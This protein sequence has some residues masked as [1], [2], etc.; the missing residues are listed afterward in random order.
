MASVFWWRLTSC[1]ALFWY[2]SLRNSCRYSD[3]CVWRGTFKD[4]VRLL[5]AMKQYLKRIKRH[6]PWLDL[7]RFKLTQALHLTTESW[8]EHKRCANALMLV[9]GRSAKSSPFH[10]LSNCGA[11]WRF[12]R[13]CCVFFSLFLS[14]KRHQNGTHTPG[15]WGRMCSY[16]LRFQREPCQS[17]THFKQHWILQPDLFSPLYTFLKTCSNGNYT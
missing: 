3:P 12:F 4:E 17:V 5:T 7:R 13:N 15:L 1:L 10:L 2:L 16:L 11:G 6:F 14:R 8:S 9:F